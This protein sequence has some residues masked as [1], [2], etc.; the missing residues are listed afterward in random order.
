M[1][2]MENE[3]IEEPQIKYCG[4]CKNIITDNDQTHQNRSKHY[5]KFCWEQLTGDIR[6]LKFE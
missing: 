3:N 5:H 1:Q 2:Q 6:E 4:Y